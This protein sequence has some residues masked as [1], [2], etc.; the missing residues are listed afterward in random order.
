MVKQGDHPREPPPCR[1]PPEKRR[2]ERPSL[3]FSI[4]LPSPLGEGQGWGRRRTTS[5]NHPTIPIR[6]NREFSDMHLC[7]T[8]FLLRLEHYAAFSFSVL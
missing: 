8:I 5:I 3:L 2:E 7:R 1:M 6:S 4:S